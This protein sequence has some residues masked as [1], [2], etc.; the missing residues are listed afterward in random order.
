M[1]R[2]GGQ[3]MD[4]AD[5]VVRA[6]AHADDA[7][8]ADLDARVAHML[9]RL[10]PVLIGTGGDDMPVIFGRGIEIVVVIIQPRLLEPR[11]LIG[12]QHAQA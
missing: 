6:F 12:R 3:R 10:Q 8:A 5:A 7:A 4:Q 11:R 1:D 2:Q 9:Q